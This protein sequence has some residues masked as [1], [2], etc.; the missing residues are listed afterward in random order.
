MDIH[1]VNVSEILDLRHAVLRFGRPID[2]AHF[3]GDD[4]PETWHV[5]AFD[6]GRV[7][8]CVTLLPSALDGAPAWQLRGMAVS[9]EAQG[10]GIGGLLLDHIETHLPPPAKLWCNA[11]GPAVRFYEKHGWSAFGAPFDVPDVGPHQ[12]M[13]R[14][15]PGV[16]S[17]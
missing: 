8:G 14:E 17:A 10:R 5:A 1:R 12:R 4:D 16:E 15:R 9:P 2:S 11:R 7:I 3:T 13:S 6:G